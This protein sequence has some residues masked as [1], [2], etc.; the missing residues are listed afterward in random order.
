[1]TSLGES[2]YESTNMA[3]ASAGSGTTTVH[4]AGSPKRVG[5]HSFI[6]SGFHPFIHSRPSGGS[7]SRRFHLWLHHFLAGRGKDLNL[8]GP[9]FS[10]LHSGVQQY[11]T[12]RTRGLLD[13]GPCTEQALRKSE[14][15]FH[16]PSFLLSFLLIRL[17][18]L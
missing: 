10:H 4:G 3:Q 5:I 1:M 14:P 13:A 9:R 2:H 17:E 16:L 6:H 7:E 11:E 15:P 12:A 18:A 8:S